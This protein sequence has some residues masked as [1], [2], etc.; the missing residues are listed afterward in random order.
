[1]LKILSI[2]LLRIALFAPFKIGKDPPKRYR[3]AAARQ[4]SPSL[5]HAPTDGRRRQMN[6][7]SLMSTHARTYQPT[8]QL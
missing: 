7:S 3:E 1:M 8:R 5:W 6:A 2:I 4:I